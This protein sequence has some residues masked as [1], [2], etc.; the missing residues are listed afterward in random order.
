MESSSTSIVDEIEREA[1]LKKQ[2]E[3]AN[4]FEATIHIE[5]AVGLQGFQ[6]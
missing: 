1:E 4:L 3:D 2:L 6:R 5:R